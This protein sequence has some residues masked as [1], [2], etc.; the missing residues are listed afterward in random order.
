MDKNKFLFDLRRGISFLRRFYF[1]RK[2]TF[3]REQ[4]SISQRSKMYLEKIMK[5]VRLFSLLILTL[6]F[7][8]V[9]ISAQIGTLVKSELSQAESDR[10]IKSFTDNEVKFREALNIYV[11]KR[12]AVIN[13]VGMGGQLTGTYHTITFMTFAEDGKRV[14]KVLFAPLPTTP[15]G[16]MTSEDLQDLG[17]VNPFALQPKVIDQYDFRLVGKQKIDSLNLYV[18]DVTPKQIPSVK[19]GL[20]LFTGRVWVDDKDLMI[21]K[22]KGKAVPDA[23]NN[24]FPVVE[25]WREN[26]DGKYW[27]PSFATSDDELIFDNGS[28]LKIRMRVYYKEY[29][30]GRSEFKIL[31]DDNEV[32]EATPPAGTVPS[33]PPPIKKP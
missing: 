16:F 32:I 27:F 30:R 14:E 17:G 28:V 33:P 23:K 15:P 2:S 20:R 25:T 6:C 24:K 3:R 5:N 22:T 18:F 8:T 7:L 4:A 31:D 26:I 11:F 9:G 19:S 29:A 12:N 10:I 1:K 13:T 21:V